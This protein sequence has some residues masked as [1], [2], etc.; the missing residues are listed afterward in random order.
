MNWTNA[1]PRIDGLSKRVDG[2]ANIIWERRRMRSQRRD[3]LRNCMQECSQS[4]RQ[5]IKYRNMNSE[6]ASI[7]REMESINTGGQHGTKNEGVKNKR[8]GGRT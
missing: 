5:P 4:D 8:E 3:W 7:E 2:D 1:R 6:R